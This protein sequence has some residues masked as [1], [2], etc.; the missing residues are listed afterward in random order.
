M[1]SKGK[2]IGI[3][4]RPKIPMYTVRVT[5]VEAHP[6]CA[7]R[8][9]VGD[10]FEI[11]HVRRGGQ[12]GFMCPS[13]FH[14]LYDIIY[15]MKY[16]AEFPWSKERDSYIAQCCD[17]INTVKFKIERLRNKIW[18]ADQDIRNKDGGR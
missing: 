18:R 15:A 3:Y 11:S 7:A 9:R 1:L 8:H 12:K 6:N 16:G 4:H 17:P 10:T 14:G 2:A 5:V 13:A